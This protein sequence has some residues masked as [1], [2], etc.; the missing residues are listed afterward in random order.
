MKKENYKVKSSLIKN[1]KMKYIE[2]QIG[3]MIIVPGIGILVLLLITYI[4]QW[5]NN[6]MS[7]SGLIIISLIFVVSL[8]L[9]FQMKTSVDNEQIRI[10]YGI[11]LIKKAIAIKNIERIEIVRNKW[12]YG[13]GIRMIKNG[14]LYNI[15]GL[16]AIELKLKN[17]KSIIRIGTADSKKLKK[18]VELK[19]NSSGIDN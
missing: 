9:F 11:G 5:G 10:S 2:R 15:Q 8:L 3:W 16:D 4:N 19:M 14:W 12:Y 18:E 7:F 6:P 1:Q 13:L 17:S